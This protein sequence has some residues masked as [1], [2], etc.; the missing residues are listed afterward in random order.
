ML[1]GFFSATSKYPGTVGPQTFTATMNGILC[2]CGIEHDFRGRTGRVDCDCGAEFSIEA[3]QQ[4]Y[5][6]APTVGNRADV[7][8]GQAEHRPSCGAVLEPEEGLPPWQAQI[9]SGRASSKAPNEANKPKRYLDQP[10]KRSNWQELVVTKGGVVT[11]NC[12]FQNRERVGRVLHLGPEYLR[13]LTVLPFDTLSEMSVDCSQ[14]VDSQPFAVGDEVS[15][16]GV[17]TPS[18]RDCGIFERSDRNTDK[19]FAQVYRVSR[20]EPNQS[21]LVHT[22]DLRLEKRVEETTK[23]RQAWKI[24][25]FGRPTGMK[26]P[27]MANSYFQSMAAGRVL[28]DMVELTARTEEQLQAKML[29]ELAVPPEMLGSF[30]L[31]KDDDYTVEAHVENKGDGVFEVKSMSKISLEV[32]ANAEA[33]QGWMHTS[34]DTGRIMD[35]KPELQDMPKPKGL[36]GLADRL[37]EFARV[38]KTTH[39]DRPR[40]MLLPPGFVHPTDEE[41]E[42]DLAELERQEKRQERIDAAYAFVDERKPWHGDALGYV[43]SRYGDC[44]LSVG[45]DEGIGAV[46]FTHTVAGPTGVLRHGPDSW[47]WEDDPDATRHPTLAAACDAIDQ[48]ALDM[49]DELVN[50]EEP[51][52]RV[53]VM[54]YI[55]TGHMGGRGFGSHR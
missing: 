31:G 37:R 8:Y 25:N 51:E 43:H 12:H 20:V 38:M 52:K 10:H 29:R 1:P 15:W 44:E 49:A 45:R 55:G 34:V 39:K 30:D 50:P 53:R 54:E 9:R 16:S 11:F 18:G 36:A 2:N 19:G 14:L 13:V 41:Y 7:S 21:V 27:R 24:R 35:R 4:R 26:L 28:H 40:H 42:A 33:N 46:D 6:P 5:A 32:N 22:A 47:E 23:W 3:M 17:N 48:W